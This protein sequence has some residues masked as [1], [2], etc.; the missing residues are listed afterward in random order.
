MITKTKEF[1]DQKYDANNTGWDLGI[2]SPPLKN[3]FDQIKN[4]DLE[5]LIPGAGNSWEAEYLFLNGFKNVNV[6]DI[7]SLAISN[8]KSRVPQFPAQQIFEQD[9][10]EHTKKYDLI[11]EQTFFCAINPELR[12]AYSLKMHELLKPQGKLVGLLFN[13]PLNTDH[14]PFGG[15]KSEYLTLF[16]SKFDL[17]TIETAH[18]SV[19][20]RKGN[21]LF[22]NFT[23]K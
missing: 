7:S 6:I 13:I 1:W 3:Y 2:I 5:I 16:S 15:N 23:R 8:F 9:F 19:S 12:T 18:N 20:P 11:I 4:K 14:P 10:F 21:E 17:N 22:I